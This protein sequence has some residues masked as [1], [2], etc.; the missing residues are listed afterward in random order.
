ME[1]E[2]HWDACWNVRDLGGFATA[3]GRQTR[4][5]TIVRAGN[6]SKLTEAGRQSLLDYG[7]RTVIDVR[8]PREFAVE[9][10]QFHDI[11]RWSGQVNYLSEPLISEAEWEAIRDPQVLRQG[12][13]VTLDL[14]MKNIGRIMSAIARAEPGAVVVHCHA[15]KERTGVVAAL[16]LALAGVPDEV[17]AEDYVDSDRFLQSFY[18]E[19]AQ[20]EA[21][22]EQRARVLRGFVSHPDHMLVPLQRLRSLGGIESYLQAAGVTHEE[23]IVLR[24]RM[25]ADGADGPQ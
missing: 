1:R 9:L 15:G 25:L 19:R 17:I 8:D 23:I 11:G 5:K 10:D 12:Y 14:S 21:D 7:V 13:V 4:W 6:L 16:L 18:A 3:S 2:L 20:L 24:E 22:P